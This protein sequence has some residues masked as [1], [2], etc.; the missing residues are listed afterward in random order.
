[1]DSERIASE[2][3]LN[4]SN[5][6]FLMRLGSMTTTLQIYILHLILP[7]VMVSPSI[8]SIHDRL[9]ASWIHSN[10]NMKSSKYMY[11]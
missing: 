10:S 4:Y 6:S 1:M 9:I 2:D 7:L 3:V 8:I 11:K 5:A